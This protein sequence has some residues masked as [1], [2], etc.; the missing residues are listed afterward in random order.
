MKYV[1][2]IPALLFLVSISVCIAKAEAAPD[3]PPAKAVD[4]LLAVRESADVTNALPEIQTLWPDQP[5]AYEKCVKH[6]LDVLAGASSNDVAKQASRRLFA[7]VAGSSIPS[8]HEDRSSLLRLKCE[9]ILR[10]LNVSEIKDDISTWLDIA[11]VQ[12]DVRSHII[13]DYVKQGKLNPTDVMQA[14]SKEEAQRAIAENRK[15]VATDRWQQELRVTDRKLTLL[16]LSNIKDV[17][18]K[19][20]EPQKGQFV[21]R[22]RSRARL[23]E[24]ETRELN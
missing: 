13:P 15:K 18:S 6:T 14:S 12:G 17:A 22:I 10:C 4:L 23:N 19:M 7:N 16:L 24:D 8:N 2:A 20:S 3:E 9:L 11:S 5:Q 1:L 21:E